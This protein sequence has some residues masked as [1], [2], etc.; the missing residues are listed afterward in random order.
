M[1]LIGILL[2]GILCWRNLTLKKQL[3]QAQDACAQAQ[4]TQTQ[5]DAALASQEDLE[6]RLDTVRS[7]LSHQLRMPLSIIKGYA[8]IL[9]DDM[10]TDPQLQR[11]YLEKIVDHSNQ[12]SLLISQNYHTFN[13]YQVST[14][15]ASPTSILPIIHQVAEDLRTTAQTHGVQIQVLPHQTPIVATADPSLLRTVL[16]NLFE[17]SLKY[18]GRQGLILVRIDTQDDMVAITVQDDG[19]GL[20]AVETEQIFN[21]DFRG[22]NA[23]Q[24]AG[25]GQG[26]HMV[27]QIILAHGGQITAKSDLGQGMRIHFT[28]PLVTQTEKEM[29][30]V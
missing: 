27:H 13:D 10:V 20:P 1:Y 28:L 15:C 12:L 23:T 3:H 11:N 16:F 21:V 17:N 7:L 8:E 6:N 14:P 24:R 5:L 22:S 30:L 9:R 25:Q 19:L 18:M 29:A 2:L 4:D 26:L